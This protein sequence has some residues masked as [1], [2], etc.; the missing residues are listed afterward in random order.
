[1][2]QEKKNHCRTKLLDKNTSVKA[3]NFVTL[4]INNYT[5]QS[6]NEERILECG[7]T[8]TCC[9]STLVDVQPPCTD[10]VQIPSFS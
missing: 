3:L 4:M 2:E 5:N 9:L 6:R 8:Y 1:M 7:Y 10:S